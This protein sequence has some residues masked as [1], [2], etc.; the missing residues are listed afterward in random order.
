LRVGRLCIGIRIK[1][2]RARRTWSRTDG[3]VFLDIWEKLMD[4]LSVS[5]AVDKMKGLDGEKYLKL[6]LYIM[7]LLPSRL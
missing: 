5:G 6:A 4:L 7:P 2:R 3:W 1:I